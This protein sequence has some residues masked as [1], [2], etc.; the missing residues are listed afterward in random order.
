MCLYPKKHHVSFCHS[1]FAE[2]RGYAPIAFKDSPSTDYG[3]LQFFNVR[4][5]K[6]GDVATLERAP[7]GGIGPDVFIR[8]MR[9]F[10]KNS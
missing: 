8:G 6:S 7:A 10:G 1:Q 5:R 2:E 9:A 3:E 4:G